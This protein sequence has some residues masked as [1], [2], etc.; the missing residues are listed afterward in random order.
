MEIYLHGIKETYPKTH[1]D[2]TIKVR[3]YTILVVTRIKLENT[4]LETTPVF[5]S[6]SIPKH[7]I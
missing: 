4:I 3:F 6:I 1:V 5:T 2:V 7:Q